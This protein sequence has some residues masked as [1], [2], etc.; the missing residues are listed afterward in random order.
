MMNQ[1][2]KKATKPTVMK[3]SVIVPA[4]ASFAIKSENQPLAFGAST[5]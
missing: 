5:T 3:P 2:E 1:E 4:T